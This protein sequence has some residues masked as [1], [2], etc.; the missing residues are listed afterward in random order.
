M[1]NSRINL[2]CAQVFLILPSAPFLHCLLQE[3]HTP[4]HSWGCVIQI[5][6]ASRN[7][8]R[9]PIYFYSTQLYQCVP[10]LLDHVMPIL[11]VKSIRFVPISYLMERIERRCLMP[12]GVTIDQRVFNE[13]AKANFAWPFCKS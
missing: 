5:L 4:S 6:K 9:K 13:A 2:I 12:G 7:L 11:L 3:L 1:S 10:N 8:V